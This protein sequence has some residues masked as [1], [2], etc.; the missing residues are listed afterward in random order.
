M[1]NDKKNEIILSLRHMQKYLKR[2][3]KNIKQKPES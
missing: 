1:I 2:E 3:K